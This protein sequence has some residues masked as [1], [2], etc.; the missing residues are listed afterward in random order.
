MQST[1]E[2][3]D[4]WDKFPERTPRKLCLPHELIPLSGADGART[5]E[6]APGRRK[7]LSLG[8]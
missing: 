1:P 4:F 3:L 8:D 7:R 6:P 5:L 2:L